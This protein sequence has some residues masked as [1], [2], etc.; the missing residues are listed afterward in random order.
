M[1]L[2]RFV[3]NDFVVFSPNQA[4]SSFPYLSLV[5]WRTGRNCRILSEEL[6][7]LTSITGNI[8]LMW[9]LTKHWKMLETYRQKSTKSLIQSLQLQSS[10]TTENVRAGCAS[11]LV[12][13]I[14]CVLR[15]VIHVLPSS[16]LPFPTCSWLLVFM[17]HGKGGWDENMFPRQSVFQSNDFFF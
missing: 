17:K 4:L 2:C 6:S 10:H 12:R 8:K 9:K 3:V 7:V 11:Y 1:E 16:F 15:N 13:M 14:V 5:K